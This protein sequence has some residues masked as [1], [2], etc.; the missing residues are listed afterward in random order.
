MDTVLCMKAPS[1]GSNTA[2]ELSKLW[3]TCEQSIRG[4]LFKSIPGLIKWKKKKTVLKNNIYK[5]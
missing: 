1:E 2:A 3:K 4:E 5:T